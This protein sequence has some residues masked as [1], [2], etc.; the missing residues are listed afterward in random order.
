M[1]GAACARVLKNAE[2]PTLTDELA[3]AQWLA[4]AEDWYGLVLRSPVLAQIGPKV[5]GYWEAVSGMEQAHSLFLLLRKTALLAGGTDGSPAW[6]P[7]IPVALLFME[8]VG[9]WLETLLGFHGRP[10]TAERPDV[11][12][13]V[14]G[15]VACPEA[16]RASA[17]LRDQ[18]GKSLICKPKSTRCRRSARGWRF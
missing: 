10:V 12:A 17:L 11:Q 2:P 13:L 14:A 16:N 7:E 9:E 15:M 6:A 5:R 18:Y 1:V 3:R 4:E 8:K